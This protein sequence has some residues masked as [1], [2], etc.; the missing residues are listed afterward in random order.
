[1]VLIALDL[2]WFAWSILLL[3]IFAAFVVILPLLAVANLFR[4]PDVVRFGAKS[5]DRLSALQICLAVPAVVYG[6]AF[7]NDINFS[8]MMA[9]IGGILLLASTAGFFLFTTESRRKWYLIPGFALCMAFYLFAAPPCVKIVVVGNRRKYPYDE[10]ED[11]G[12]KRWR[13]RGESRRRRS[14]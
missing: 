12:G 8:D 2:Y 1:M 7:L 5:K 13:T 3:R 10:D 4:S 9:L 14:A 11:A 6:I